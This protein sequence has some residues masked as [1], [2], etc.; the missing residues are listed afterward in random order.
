MKR[1][2]L[3]TGT[4]IAA[5]VLIGLSMVSPAAPQ[6][7]VSPPSNLNALM[8]L[9][10][11]DEETMWQ[12]VKRIESA[13]GRIVH[14]HP[15]HVLIGYLDENTAQQVTMLPHVTAIYRDLVEPAET[16]QY[17]ESIVRGIQ[18]WNNLLQISTT[19]RPAN[20]A[21]TPAMRP[22]AF[23][24]PT[25]TPGGPPPAPGWSET[26]SYM[27]GK[28]VVSI[29]FPESNGA[30]DPSTEDWDAT[31]LDHAQTYVMNGLNW[32]AA[33]ESD[34]HLTL[35]YTSPLTV[36][37]GYEP[38]SHSVFPDQKL[39][40]GDV[41]TALGYPPPPGEYGYNAAV[42]NYINAL[43]ASYQTDW[44]V[45]AF[46]V[47][48]LND[49]D[50]LFADGF[51]GYA[52]YNGPFFVITYGND[53]W[54]PEKMDAI[55]A[56]EF[57]HVFWALDQYDYGNGSQT[58]ADRSGYLYEENQNLNLQTTCLSD[59]LSIMRGSVDVGFAT[60]SLDS[61]GRGQ[62]GWQDIDG[63]G[64]LNPLDTTPVLTVTGY[65]QDPSPVHAIVYTGTTYDI[66]IPSQSPHIPDTTINTIAGVQ[67]RVAGGT[68]SNSHPS[69]GAFDS[70][71]E[72]FTSVLLLPNGTYTIELRSINSVSNISAIVT[73]TVVVSSTTPL[74][75]TY[76]PLALRGST[77][78]GK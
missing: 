13:G 28:V 35:V 73:D 5:F 67:K 65:P 21:A 53:G 52:Y 14:I 68:W 62:I 20:V 69:D 47:D 4:S 64:I 71:V 26:S 22:D 10:V 44:A 15:P 36:S 49:S 56:H 46:V 61:Y 77:S 66:P 40:I 43:R 45:V 8:V 30:I 9:D 39:W 74:Y 59:V 76:L 32:W 29:I 18:L 42:R 63:D 34:A 60:N 3:L 75:I 70:S 6:T 41:M 1:M 19:T 50:N 55:A 27:I 31:R 38:I 2:I 16:A 48:D 24:F 23:L 72:G 37:T 11:Q 25:P 17:K 54:G 78:W 58:C 7:S 57:G 12:T 51:S 33:R